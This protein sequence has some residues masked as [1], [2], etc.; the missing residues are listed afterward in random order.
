MI[1][2]TLM[3]SLL[4]SSS[5]NTLYRSQKFESLRTKFYIFIALIKG[6]CILVSQNIYQAVNS[7]LKPV[8]DDIDQISTRVQTISSQLDKI[9]SRIKAL[10]DQLTNIEDSVK[11]KSKV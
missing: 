5:I 4:T 9:E 10:S 11:Q 8:K 1:L 6:R 3:N 2:E 7:C